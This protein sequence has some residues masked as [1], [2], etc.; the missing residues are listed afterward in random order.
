MDRPVFSFRQAQAAFDL[1]AF[2][3]SADEARLAHLGDEWVGQVIFDQNCRFETEA[4]ACA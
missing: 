4:D 3:Q 1:I 2:L